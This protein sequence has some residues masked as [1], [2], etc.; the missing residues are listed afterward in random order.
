MNVVFRCDAGYIIGAGHFM[1]CL[2]LALKLRERGANSFFVMSHVN[3]FV[4]QKLAFH[5]FAFFELCGADDAASCSDYSSWLPLGEKKDALLT[6]KVLEKLPP[7]SAIVVDHYR[8]AEKWHR[9][10]GKSFKLIVIDDLANRRHLAHALIDSNE[11]TDKEK[12]YLDLAP[13]DCKLMLGAGYAMLDDAV[14]AFRKTAQE[15]K[16]GK[17]VHVCFGGSDHTGETLK[18]IEA[19]VLI[20]QKHLT[21]AKSGWKFHVVCGPQN[22]DVCKI[23]TLVEPLQNV[24]LHV[25]PRSHFELMARASYAY[26]AGGTMTWERAS[27]FLPMALV[28][29]AENQKKV[30]EDLSEMKMIHFLGDAS[31]V[32]NLDYYEHILRLMKEG[33]KIVPKYFHKLAGIS[34]GNGTERIVDWILN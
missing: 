24:D 4:R 26:G 32:T 14:L 10:I 18:F 11:Y 1:R 15:K 21:L 19:V 3:D 29:T 6:Q 20:N 34:D 12:R 33:E 30:C 2:R 23:Q 28:A 25:D 13:P 17:V 5:G 27:L 8:I 7:V 22:K 9:N 16:W 31:E